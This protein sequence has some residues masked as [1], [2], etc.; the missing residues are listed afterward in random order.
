MRYAANITCLID[1]DMKAHFHEYITDCPNPLN[2]EP[3]RLVGGEQK[4]HVDLTK[5]SLF[6]FHLHHLSTTLIFH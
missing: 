4:I 5:K 1:M 3:I 6:I 2:H